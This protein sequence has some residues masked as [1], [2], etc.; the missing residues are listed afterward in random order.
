MTRTDHF[1]VVHSADDRRPIAPAGLRRIGFPGVMA[2][3]PELLTIVSLASLGLAGFAVYLLVAS[4]PKG[5]R[6]LADDRQAVHLL[7]QHDESIVRLRAAVRQLAGEQRRQAETMLS[8]VQRIGLV[9]YDAF[10][11]MGGHLSFSAALL[12]GDGDGIVIT[13]INGRQDTRCYAKPVQAWTSRHNL[14]EE[15]E[16]AI[17]QALATSGPAPAVPMDSRGRVRP[18]A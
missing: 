18:G 12:D 14:S 6:K 7:T 4:A 13:S 17:Q 2:L 1:P 3:S 11:D 15:E 5:G 16:A 8:A 9:R 10:E